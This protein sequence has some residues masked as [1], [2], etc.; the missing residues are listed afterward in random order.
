MAVREAA[1]RVTRELHEKNAGGP[2][3]SP[4]D[5]ILNFK[6]VFQAR[7]AKDVRGKNVA[8]RY[9]PSYASK[10]RGAAVGG[11]VTMDVEVVLTVM[12]L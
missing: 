11:M 10:L 9:V 12:T 5:E 1:S 8:C 4:M 3:V 6:S 7:G 2:G